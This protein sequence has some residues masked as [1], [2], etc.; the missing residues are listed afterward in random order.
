MAHTMAAPSLMCTD[1]SLQ[2][3]VTTAQLL[4]DIHVL[5][6]A[7]H[8]LKPCLLAAAAQR[9][10]R[11][12]PPLQ[13]GHHHDS[14]ALYSRHDIASLNIQNEIRA[15]K[16]WRPQRSQSTSQSPS[17]QVN[18]WESSTAQE[19]PACLV[20]IKRAVPS[21]LQT[22]ATPEYSTPDGQPRTAWAPQ[23]KTPLQVNEACP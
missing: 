18:H 22:P 19:R 7:L 10:L 17:Q 5:S 12:E 15:T 3:W 8:S 16:G 23:A 2:P 1:A 11:K 20:T 4:S 13:H 6:L 21:H 14:T 9:E